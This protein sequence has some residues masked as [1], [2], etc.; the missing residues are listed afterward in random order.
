[1]VCWVEIV[2]WTLQ[3]ARL[4]DGR[5]HCLTFGPS[6]TQPFLSSQL[7]RPAAPYCP[8]RLF[9]TTTPHQHVTTDLIIRIVQP[10]KEIKW[11]LPIKILLW[12]L[13][14]L[15][16]ACFVFTPCW[17]FRN[18]ERS[19]EVGTP[20]MDASQCLHTSGRMPPFDSSSPFYFQQPVSVKVFLALTAAL[21][22]LW[23]PT[24]CNSHNF[25]G[26]HML[27]RT[28][29]TTILLYHYPRP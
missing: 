22:V 1:M 13:K 16:L 17:H 2:R 26:F 27:K 7:T 29:Y 20:G 11:T 14:N 6:G 5:R 10:H 12:I 24:S 21:Y 15:V 3:E 19:V 8:L 9:I 25:Y 23:I 18:G 4:W 28:H